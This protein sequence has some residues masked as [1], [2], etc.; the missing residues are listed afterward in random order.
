[1]WDWPVA[2]PMTAPVRGAADAPESTHP[3]PALRSC[4]IIWVLA[5]GD[6][7][8]NDRFTHGLL[9]MDTLLAADDILNV[10]S[11]IVKKFTPRQLSGVYCIH[12]NWTRGR[13]VPFD[14]PAGHSI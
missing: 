7:P 8:P 2:T 14:P 9:P 10:R 1:M 5:T 3:P 6:V 13:S 12:V 4:C 11:Y